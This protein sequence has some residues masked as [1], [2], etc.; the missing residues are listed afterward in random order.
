MTLGAVEPVDAGVL[1]FVNRASDFL[2]AAARFANRLEGRPDVAW[3]QD[4]PAP[5]ADPSA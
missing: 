3:D 2:F 1:K 4:L 5:E